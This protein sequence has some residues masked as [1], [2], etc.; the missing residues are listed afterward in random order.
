MAVYGYVWLCRAVYGCVWPCMAMYG[1]VWL[2][3][4]MCGY[5]GLCM[6]VYGCVWLWMSV[7]S[8]VCPYRPAR[9]NYSGRFMGHTWTTNPGPGDGDG[10]EGWL[11]RNVLGC[12]GVGKFGRNRKQ[13]CVQVSSQPTSS[14]QETNLPIFLQG[15]GWLVG[16]SLQKTWRKAN[17]S[18]D[19]TM[20][21]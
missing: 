5:V 12:G 15:R 16:H 17:S 18:I 19:M 2:C 4:A 7:Y 9:R 8:Y 10:L 13:T 6:A 14:P 1:C 20:V 21:M 3:M 11:L